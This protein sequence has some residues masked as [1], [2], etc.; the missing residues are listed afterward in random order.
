MV[1]VPTIAFW[2]FSFDVI[3]KRSCCIGLSVLSDCCSCELF[4]MVFW[5]EILN[6]VVVLVK[7]MS[8][9]GKFFFS[10][11]FAPRIF[12]FGEY[13]R[14]LI[15]S[16]EVWPSKSQLCSLCLFLKSTFHQNK[17]INFFNYQIFIIKLYEHF[18]LK[19]TL[20]TLKE[21]FCISMLKFFQDISFSKISYA[22]LFF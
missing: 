13:F 2:V 11:I 19:E 18:F 12:F 7:L 22:R 21:L 14:K 10:T 15:S 4:A 16:V 17:K 9:R 3:A 20:I 8:F 6:D 1:P 5:E